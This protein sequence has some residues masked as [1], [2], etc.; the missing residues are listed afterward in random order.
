MAVWKKENKNRQ[1]SSKKIPSKVPPT[2]YFEMWDIIK[3]EISQN[4]FRFMSEWQFSFFKT[5]FLMP[6]NRTEEV[7]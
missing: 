1:R 7:F 3:Y 2:C 4:K 5:I 6:T